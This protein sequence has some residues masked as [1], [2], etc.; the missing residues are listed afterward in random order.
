[1]MTISDTTVAIIGAGYMAKEHIKAFQS[2]PGVAVRGIYSRTKERA[3]DLADEFAIPEV[4]S[5]IAELYEAT[6]ADLVVV[7]VPELAAKQVSFECF[8]HPWVM[9]MEKPVGY[10]YSQALEIEAEAKKANRTVF[11][12]LNRRFYSSTTTVLEV[13]EKSESKRFIEVFDQQDINLARSI[14]HPEQVVENWMYANSIHL[15]DYLQL[16]GRG[17]VVEVIPSA[18]WNSEEPTVVVATVRFSSGDVG[19]YHG[20]WN[21]PGPWAVNVTTHEHRWEMRPLEQVVYQ[22]AGERVLNKVEIDPC[23]VEYKAGIKALAEETV[24]AVKGL[25]TKAVPLSVANI[26]MKLVHDIYE[27]KK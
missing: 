19:V 14:G 16:L 13:L 22:N 27:L 18:S 7:A 15:I 11:V 25:P 17:D 6:K 21:G 5:S 23:D 9:L 2:I 26:S 10:N 4:S 20:I 1:M 24:K 3:Q 12:A 8:Q